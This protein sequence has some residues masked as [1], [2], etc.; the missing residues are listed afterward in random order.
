MSYRDLREFLAKLEAEGQL[1]NFQN[2]ILPKPD[3]GAICRVASDIGEMGPAVVLDS[4]LCNEAREALL[5]SKGE[6]DEDIRVIIHG[7][8][9][10]LFENINLSEGD[11]ISFVLP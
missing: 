5:N 8:P 7:N 4:G 1:I 2:E 10:T 11:E 6:V 3:I 9:L